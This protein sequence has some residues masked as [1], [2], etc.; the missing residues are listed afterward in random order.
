M[1][2]SESILRRI[3]RCLAQQLSCR[4]LVPAVLAF[5]FAAGAAPA[6]A[7]APAQK[8]FATPEAAVAELVAAARSGNQKRLRA[9]FGPAGARLGNNDPALARIERKAF[10]DAY[11]EKHAIELS[12]DARATLVVGAN[13]WRFPVPL[14]RTGKGWRFDTAAG[15][16]E[17]INRRVGRNELHAI[18]TL[19]A[20]VDAQRE[21]A[22]EDR[23]GDGLRDYAQKFAS[24]PGKRDGLYWPA[25]A[26]EA[27]SPLGA[28]VAG[29]AEEGY[30]LGSGVPRP[31][32]GYYFRILTAQGSNARG[33]AYD[34][35]VGS[36]LIG[37]FAVL[38][39]PAEYGQS[40]VKSFLVNH[41]GVVFEKD[42][43]AETRAL[44]VAIKD[45]NPDASWHEAA[46]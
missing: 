46:R 7:A 15:A 1:S 10:V 37:G 11:T 43:G 32:W 5:A 19:L 30:A 27:P 13:E 8:T 21:Y 29:A 9:V 36:N 14:V 28:L 40:G 41:E 31:Y 45:F 12:G 35:L 39:F 22:A 20:L 2:V 34:Y 44:A 3:T 16:E 42:L 33:G 26:G 38:A 4:L 17:V 24:S 18:Q 25:A 6:S 23:D